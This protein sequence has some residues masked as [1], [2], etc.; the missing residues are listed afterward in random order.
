MSIKTSSI[1]IP[2][3]FLICFL[4]SIS[5]FSQNTEEVEKYKKMY[6][7]ESSVRLKQETIYR[8]QLEKNEIKITKEVFEQDLFLNENATYN[9]KRSL[10]YS[11]FIDLEKIEASTLSPSE[12]SYKEIPVKEFNRKNDLD[13]SFYDDSKRVS[14]LFPNLGKGSKTNFSYT[15]NIKNPRFLSPFFFGDFS[16]ILKSKV[17]II[18]DKKIDLSFKEFNTDNLNIVFEKKKGGIIKKISR[19][20]QFYA[21]NKI[22]ERVKNGDYK[23]GLIWHTQG[24]GKTLTMFFTAWKLRYE[25]ELKNPKVKVP[26]KSK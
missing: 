26:S 4:F 14:F 13:E 3:S 18:A 10:S 17:T 6:P 22:V 23:K 21:T 9:T 11:T 25:T 20:Q 16:P 2:F 5:I 7:N 15:Y 12:G 19:Y 8:L 24:S 1:S